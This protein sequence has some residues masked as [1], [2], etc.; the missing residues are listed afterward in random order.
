MKKRLAGFLCA[1][2]F[3]SCMVWVVPVQ[4][5]AAQEDS[6]VQ[7]EVSPH[8]I[9]M[10]QLSVNLDLNNGVAYCRSTTQA[11]KGYT[12]KLVMVLK[13]N[14]VE[15]QKWEGM[16]TNDTM[17]LYEPCNITHGHV[18]QLVATA[19][20]YNSAGKLVETPTASTGIKTY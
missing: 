10:G 3:M 4:A 8:Y 20:V 19:Y 17:A 14:N 2:L 18:Y 7:E 11:Y 12:I 16:V 13:R 9:G 5:H 15:F 6:A 1:V